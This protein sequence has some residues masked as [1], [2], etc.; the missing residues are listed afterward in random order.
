MITLLSLFAPHIHVVLFFAPHI[1]VVLFFVHI[2]FVVNR[3]F[4]ATPADMLQQHPLLF[5]RNSTDHTFFLWRLHLARPS[6]PG[7]S[8]ILL[9]SESPSAK[10][11][12]LHTLA[13]SNNRDQ[14]Q[15]SL[16]Y[17]LFAPHIYVV[18]FFAHIPFVVNCTFNATPVER[19]QQYQHQ[20]YMRYE[21]CQFACVVLRVILMPS[22]K[23]WFSYFLSMSWRA[24]YFAF[25]SAIRVPVTFPASNSCKYNMPLQK[26]MYLAI[27]VG[28][29]YH[30]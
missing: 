1:H 19:L 28:V 30:T 12:K 29:R 6:H 22:W 26:T 13:A 21:W 18:L 9:R 15:W 17:C 25:S 16:Y 8:T 7:H 11:A 10:C 20:N 27:A 24:V 2:P 3:T 14:M 4:N 5:T 23:K